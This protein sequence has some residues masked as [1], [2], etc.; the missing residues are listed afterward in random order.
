MIVISYSETRFV[1]G[2]D[3]VVPHDSELRIIEIIKK[4]LE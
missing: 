1:S 2:G 3:D 4:L